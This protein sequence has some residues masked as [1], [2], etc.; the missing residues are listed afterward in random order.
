MKAKRRM[1][2]V[3]TCVQFLV[4]SIPQFIYSTSPTASQTSRLISPNPPYGRVKTKLLQNAFQSI[5]SNT[6]FNH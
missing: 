4:E 5:K 2:C 1:V 3:S 6:S